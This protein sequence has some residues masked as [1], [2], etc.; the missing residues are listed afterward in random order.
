MRRSIATV[1]LNGHGPAELQHVAF[2]TDDVKTAVRRTRAAGLPTLTVPANDDDDLEARL[3][4]DTTELRERRG[5]YAGYGA[6]NSPFRM[7]AQRT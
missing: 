6:T 1:C 4:G 7:A 5:G 3:G 2:A